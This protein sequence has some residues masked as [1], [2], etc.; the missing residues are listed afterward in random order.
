MKTIRT[1]ATLGSVLLIAA[2][3]TRALAQAASSPGGAPVQL[4]PV[5]VTGDLWATDLA[6]TS[7]SVTVFDATRLA[8]SGVQSFGDLIA[9]TANVTW[10]GG[11]SRARFFQVR[12]IGENSQFEGE[13]PDA[14]VRFVIDDLDFTGLGGAAT[15]FDVQQVEVLRGPQAGAFGANAAG[16]L[17]KVVTAEPTAVREGYVTATVGDDALRRGGFAVG[18]PLLADAPKRLTFRLAA[19]RTV[20]DGFRDNAFLGRSD[21][22]AIDELSVRLKV[23]LRA[24]DAWQWDAT[25]FYADQDNGYDE[26][27]LD[28][29]G[30][31]TFSDE[32]GRDTQES[33]AGSLRGVYTGDALV[34]TTRTSFTG[35]ESDYSFDSDWTFAADPRGYDSFLATERSRD[36][37]NQELRLDSAPG[38]ERR[39]TVGAYYETTVEDTFLTED[40]G[41]AT[42]RFDAT[43]LALFGQVGFTLAPAKRLIVGARVENY[44]L[45][46]RI[47]FRDEVDFDDTLL[48]GKVTLEHDLSE[49]ALVFATVTRGYKAGGANIY[50]FLVVPDEGPADYTTETLW[51]YELGWRGRSDDGRVSGEVTAFYLDRRDPQVRDSAGFGDSF[52]Y[53]VDNGLRASI[54]GLDASGRIGLTDTL[55]AYASLGLMES[56]LGAFTIDNTAAT[57]AGG[58]ELANV[59]T[60]TYTVG[61]RFGRADGLFATT[62]LSGR[63]AYFESNTH[64]EKRSAFTVVN[65]S[66]GYRREAWSVTVWARNVFDEQYEKRIFYF[67]NAGPNFETT[68]YESPADPRQVGVSARWEF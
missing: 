7:A 44:D 59:P 62:E 40:F 35:T 46:T 32:P 55:S 36:V 16:G 34:F 5:V 52:T 67:G 39:W 27:S 2:A 49:R 51:N 24:S 58:R 1:L 38:A 11:T 57:P 41:G 63:A 19:E 26:F 12:G 8:D 50:N 54:Y 18:G 65:V 29:T 20:A 9:A 28:N 25:V 60:Y 42:T 37:F 53:F 14:S 31:T 22:N 17:I 56:D 68:R 21:T 45:A 66:L 6:R 10:T 30:F 13:T 47:E 15:L 64:A 3:P 43:T 61:G 23:R 48:G 33:V 4:A